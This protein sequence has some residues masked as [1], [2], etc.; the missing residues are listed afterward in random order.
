MAIRSIMKWRHKYISAQFYNQHTLQL[1]YRRKS[2][3]VL[4]IV[5]IGQSYDQYLP[6]D[7]STTYIHNGTLEDKRRFALN[8]TSYWLLQIVLQFLISL[9]YMFGVV[10]IGIETSETI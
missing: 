2:D 8:C 3:Q 7:Y 4:Y 6:N 1:W 5:N 9:F 10:I